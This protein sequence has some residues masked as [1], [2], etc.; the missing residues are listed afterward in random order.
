MDEDAQV[1]GEARRERWALAALA[2][3]WLA[4]TAANYSWLKLTRLEASA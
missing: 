3:L 4:H 2:L 1:R